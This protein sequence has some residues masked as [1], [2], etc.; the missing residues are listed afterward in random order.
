MNLTSDAKVG[1]QTALLFG[2]PSSRISAEE[3]CVIFDAVAKET[4]TYK[5]KVTKFPLQTGTYVTDHIIV[6][7]DV[8]SF[9]V[10]VSN[11]PILVDSRNLILYG[12]EYQTTNIGG[13]T[14]EQPVVTTRYSTY[15]SKYAHDLLLDL[16]NNK[17]LLTINIAHSTFSN[18]AITSL[19][20]KETA[21]NHLEADITVERLRFIQGG[22]VYVKA[23][24]QPDA[25]TTTNKGKQDG[26]T[27]STIQEQSA[28]VELWRQGKKNLTTLHSSD[29]GSG[30]IVDKLNK[31]QSSH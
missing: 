1:V 26:T 9:T 22:I 4:S 11:E 23:D 24:K 28:L 14:D 20:F 25:K 29:S 10:Y 8:F 27:T 7:N 2:G 6:E 3:K 17:E 15:R 21:A 18:C 31:T 16:R 13:G 5:N 19:E 30:Q 12:T